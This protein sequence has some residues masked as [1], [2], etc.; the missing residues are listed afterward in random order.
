MERQISRMRRAL[1][2]EMVKD[3]YKNVSI[4]APEYS[5]MTYKITIT[6]GAVGSY[7][8]SR[9]ALLIQKIISRHT[10]STIRSILTP[11]TAKI[12]S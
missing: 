5:D 7:L 12:Q 6:G 10:K 3:A 2:L 1:A 9:V 11:I 8:Y 4:Q